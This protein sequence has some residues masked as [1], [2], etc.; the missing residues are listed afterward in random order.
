MSNSNNPGLITTVVDGYFKLL[1]FFIAFCLLAMV[2]LVFGNVVLRYA[3]NS[4]ISISEELSRWFFVWMTF[5]GA[6]IGLREHAHLGVDSF[7]NRLSPSGK[8]FC[9]VAAQVLMLWASWIL[10]RGSWDQTMINI[11]VEAPTS[12]LS[13]AFIYG[14]GVFFGGNA[15][16]I[17]LADL[18]RV[19]SGK[20]ADHELVMVKESEEVVHESGDA[21]N[22]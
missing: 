3:F 18:Y 10:L 14:I 5:I 4:G 17:I 9:L 1:K 6:L 13:M 11:D 8:R 15:M 12:G 7:V 2:I 16:L 22:K 20:L 21:H 19:L